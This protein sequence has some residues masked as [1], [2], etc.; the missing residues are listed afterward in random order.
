MKTLLLAVTLGLVANVAAKTLP[1]GDSL[2]VEIGPDWVHSVEKVTPIGSDFGD[3]VSVR[4]PDGVGVL[5]L[6]T[7]TAPANI[8]DEA[9]R[10]LTNVPATESLMK[11]QWGNFQGFRHDYVESDLFHRTWWLANGGKVV[12]ITYECGMGQQHLEIDQIER[13]IQ[14]LTLTS[15]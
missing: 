2:R 11:G 7:Y 9:L 5:R 12:F 14:S 3:Q 1:L 6:R 10:R 8:S 13:I 4:H 15:P